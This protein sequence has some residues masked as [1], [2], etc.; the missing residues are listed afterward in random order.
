MQMTAVASLFEQ[1][2]RLAPANDHTG[3]WLADVLQKLPLLASR[4][5]LSTPDRRILV[6]TL[7]DAL[8]YPCVHTASLSLG[9]VS[10]SVVGEGQHALACLCPQLVSRMSGHLGGSARVFDQPATPGP[11]ANAMVARA[12]HLRSL[13]WHLETDGQVAVI[14]LYEHVEWLAVPEILRMR[15]RAPIA[16]LLHE[17]RLPTSHCEYRVF[18]DYEIGHRP[19][20]V[21]V[22]ANP[23]SRQDATFGHAI[24]LQQVLACHRP[25]ILESIARD[26]R[27]MVAPA[28]A[29]ESDAMAYSVSLQGEVAPGT[30]PALAGDL[31]TML[32][33][34]AQA[35]ESPDVWLSHTDTEVQVAGGLGMAQRLVEGLTLRVSRNDGPISV[36]P[37]VEVLAEGDD[38]VQVRLLTPLLLP[39][40]MSQPLHVHEFLN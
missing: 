19:Q 29:Q 18:A 37:M 33:E 31:F 16:E 27:E 12:H 7:A 22:I 1:R 17:S 11:T 4:L 3:T 9:D 40:D 25:Y 38:H 39:G 13:H 21:H 8:Q 35:A 10:V 32:L 24:S 15:F 6:R 28:L 34:Q 36:M 2:A 5:P 26:G 20:V 30:S 14:P 23:E